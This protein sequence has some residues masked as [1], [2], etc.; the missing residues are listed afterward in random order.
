MR[1]LGFVLLILVQTNHLY[2]QINKSNIAFEIRYPTPI[3]HNFINSTDFKYNGI[4]D[5][6]IGYNFLK[7]KNL[8]LGV[9][10]NASI[11]R[12]SIT[13]VTL[14][15]LSPKLKIDYKINVKRI[16]IVPNVAVGYSNWRFNSSNYT[17][18]YSGL[19]FKGGTKVVLNKNNRL[20][21]YMLLAY[22]FTRL[23][24]PSEPVQNSNYTRN[25]QILYPGIGVIWKYNGE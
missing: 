16:S 9:L 11:L 3:G 23:E 21:W 10:F 20:N 24:K 4:V 13:D 2:S 8:E 7:V 18:N 1:K 5:I 19:T 25:I 6:G 15:T 14:T 12:F 17:E 22:E